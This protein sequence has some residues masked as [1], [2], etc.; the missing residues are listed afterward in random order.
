MVILLAYILGVL[1]IIP[2]AS[3]VGYFLKDEQRKEY[4]LSE[5]K[6][7]S[8]EQQNDV[9]HTIIYGYEPIP[10]F[11]SSADLF[12]YNKYKTYKNEFYKRFEEQINK[13]ENT[14]E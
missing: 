11:G 7:L 1:T 2:V 13:I 6:M 9:L 14:G 4:I 10:R 12:D 5:Y 3:L 8:K